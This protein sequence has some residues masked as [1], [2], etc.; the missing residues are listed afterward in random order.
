MVEV[1]A[2]L[3]RESAPDVQIALEATID[4]VVAMRA[5]VLVQKPIGIVLAGIHIGIVHHRS[6]QLHPFALTDIAFCN[7]ILH[8]VTLQLGHPV[9]VGDGIV[10]A[11]VL[12]IDV[13]GSG[14]DV[15]DG[16]AHRTT[17]DAILGSGLSVVDVGVHGQAI[18]ELVG[19]TERERVADVVVR[20]NEAVCVSVGSREVA[21]NLLRTA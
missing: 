19:L 9:T 8:K 3:Q 20:L 15:I 5:L 13:A 7:R 16:I 21:L 14:V 1:I 12:H 17:T 4:A 10:V 18:P 11:I 2:S 6:A